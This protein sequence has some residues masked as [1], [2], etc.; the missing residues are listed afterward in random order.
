MLISKMLFFSRELTVWYLF[1]QNVKNGSKWSN[2]KPKVT[3]YQTILLHLRGNFALVSKMSS[4][5]QKIDHL[6]HYFQKRSQQMA[7]MAQN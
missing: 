2:I 4:F 6:V 1:D 3:F 7:Q 5:T